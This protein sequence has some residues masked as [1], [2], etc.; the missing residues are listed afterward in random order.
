MPWL[1]IKGIGMIAGLIIGAGV[2]ALP[3]SF[4]KA[5][6]FW[7]VSH[8]FIA[9]FIVF[10]LHQWY[11]EVSYYTKGTHRFV[12][13]VDIYLGKKAKFFAL[14]TT[15][16]AYYGSLL[17]Y[18]IMGGV[19]LS[20]FTALF[21]GH[22]IEVLTLGFFALGGALSLFGLSKVA[23]INFFLTIPI[24]GFI[25]YL[26]FFSVPFMKADNFLSPGFSLLNKNWLLPYGI[27]L[28]SLTGFSAIPP[29]RDLFIRSS[30]VKFK[31]AIN[32]SLLLATITYIIF[33]VSV[34]GVSGTASTEDAFSGLG[35]IVGV[36]VMAIGS[37]IGFL[38]VF[39]SFIAL[40]MDM[41]SMFRYDYKIPG[42]FAWLLVVI[43]P[44]FLYLND[45]DGLA[46]TLSIIGSLGMGALGI[47]VVLMR[48]KIVKV[49]KDGDKEDIVAEIDSSKIKIIRKLEIIILSGII[50]GV[51]YDL[52]GIISS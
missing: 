45:V 14:L 10:F 52:W 23:E 8:L 2:F 7:G 9:F 46:S 34:L 48:R 5:G 6:L 16:G 37:V 24:V 31:K 39:T 47:F 26:F 35:A 11:G 36:K 3:Y 43:P 40:A 28:F 21:N 49:L 4:A 12:G 13:Y 42:F 38:A 44:V 27:W 25:I 30:L 22:T 18:G 33:I 20:N 19:F 15:L 32:I 51:I 1:Y 17:V 41:K 50:I 29:T